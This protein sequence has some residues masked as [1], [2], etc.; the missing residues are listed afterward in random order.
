MPAAVCVVWFVRVRKSRGRGDPKKTKNQTTRV[1]GKARRRERKGGTI[2]RPLS[3]HT[4]HPPLLTWKIIAE[5][6]RQRAL[7]LW[8]VAAVALALTSLPLS[9]EAPRAADRRVHDDVARLV[10]DL[11]PG[12]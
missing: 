7:A 2:R 6:S 10:G 9:G 1:L 5:G 3:P 11:P 12:D 8:V 4:V